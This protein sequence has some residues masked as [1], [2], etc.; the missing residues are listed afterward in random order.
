MRRLDGHQLR[1]STCQRTVLDGC[2]CGRTR[3]SPHSTPLHQREHVMSQLLAPGTA[4]PDSDSALRLIKICP[5][6]NCAAGGLLFSFYPADWSPVCGDQIT[7]Y[8][9]VR[10]EFQNY[11]AEI[12]GISV[13]GAW[14]H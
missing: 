2:Q 10:P 8:N 4:V 9:Q 13:D 6:A 7:L 5:S 12:L 11:G 14:C 1:G 3:A